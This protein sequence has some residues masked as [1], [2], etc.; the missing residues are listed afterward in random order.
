MLDLRPAAPT[1]TGPPS[2]DYGQIPAT[3]TDA[4]SQMFSGFY[5]PGDAWGSFGASFTSGP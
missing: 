5:L 1:P 4:G 2:W 3:I